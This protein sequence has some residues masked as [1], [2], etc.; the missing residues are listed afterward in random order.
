MWIIDSETV[1]GNLDMLSRVGW[2][3]K[4]Y[5]EGT[6]LPYRFRMRDDDGDI[7]YTGRSD[8]NSSEVAFAP[9]DDLGTPDA[10]ATEIQY[11]NNGIWET[12]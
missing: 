9:L 3:S 5:V 8:D 4:D 6:D 10:G 12:L 11:L 2:T 7:Y 1:T